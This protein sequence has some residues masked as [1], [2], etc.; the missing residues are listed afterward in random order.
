MD[1]TPSKTRPRRK[2][3]GCSNRTLFRK[4]AGGSAL[5]LGAE[6]DCLSKTRPRRKKCGCS[7][8]TLFRKATGGSALSL[9]AEFDCS[10]E[11]P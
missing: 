10:S 9:G 8:R 6:F 4:A 1:F 5:S 11:S 3:C 2:K 7:N